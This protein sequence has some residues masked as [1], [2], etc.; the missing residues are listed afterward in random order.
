MIFQAQKIENLLAA[1]LAFLPV[2][3]IGATVGWGPNH[4]TYLVAGLHL[5]HPELW[6]NDW[7][8]NQ[9]FHYD[10]VFSYLVWGLE[11]AGILKAGLALANIAAIFAGFYCLFLI[12]R[13]RAPDRAL[14]I[15]AATVFAFVF[16]FEGRGVATSTL[17]LDTFQPSSLGTLGYLLGFY[18]FIRGRFGLSGVS[19]AAFGLFQA[20]FL[21]LAFPVFGL[22]HLFSREPGLGRR[23]FKQMVPLTVGLALLLP[24]ILATVD[25]AAPRE[26]T[27]RALN[28]IFR[29]RSPFHYD[30]STFGAEF[31][32]FF[33]WV[34]LAV[35]AIRLTKNSRPAARREN[36]LYASMA[37]VLFAAV[38][39]ALTVGS[40]LAARFYFWRL[41]PFVSLLSFA[42]C[43]E[44]LFTER[45][46]GGLPAR[47]GYVTWANY[48]LGATMVLGLEF[49]LKIGAGRYRFWIF[50]VTG[51]WIVAGLGLKMLSRRF[52]W[53]VVETPAFRGVVLALAVAV[54]LTHTLTEGLRPFDRCRFVYLD[55][56][57]HTDEEELYRAAE[58]LTPADAIFVTPPYLVVFRLF[59]ERSVVAS[60]NE[61]PFSPRQ[62]IE[63]FE[64]MK[65][66]FGMKEIKTRK[67]VEAAYHNQSFENLLL[68]QKKY[69]VQYVVFR[70]SRAVNPETRR[71]LGP[72]LYEN[73][74]F[75]MFALGNPGP[76]P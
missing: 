17:F 2:L 26:I 73:G 68:L 50:W 24:S 38:V 39:E 31:I 47:S 10:I 76:A 53:K 18:F 65:D 36:V 35:T 72:P 41:V 4:S 51:L 64:R 6:H 62:T 54:P 3:F 60:W 75:L 74:G 32:S 19:L 58:H 49:I 1:L 70:K 28:I 61:V 21:I 22:A 44:A 40:N 52:G 43:F 20:N 59:A 42:F 46:A 45:S 69:G 16:G 66:S 63:W 34:L 5:A 27:E 7:W 8:V 57:C 71:R 23:L 56:G 14:A 13:S 29:I 67:E 11:K 48:S 12:I 55:A 33:G 30:F 37:L 9:T 25:L 15:F